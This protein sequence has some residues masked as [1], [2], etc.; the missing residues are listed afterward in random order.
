MWNIF[1]SLGVLFISLAISIPVFARISSQAVVLGLVL[2]LAGGIVLVGV[3]A[4]ISMDKE[5]ANQA[6]LLKANQT[7]SHS[8]FSVFQ[9]IRDK[10]DGLPSGGVGKIFL[11]GSNTVVVNMGDGKM[12]KGFKT[13]NTYPLAVAL[14]SDN[15]ILDGSIS[16]ESNHWCFKIKEGDK[17]AYYNQ[18]GLVVEN[19]V[20]TVDEDGFLKDSPTLGLAACLNGVVYGSDGKAE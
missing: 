7:F 8:S 18:H 1:L 4:N 3:G 14:P 20:T 19:V 5:K 11:Q 9:V 12:S 17:I 10:Q 16:S 13:N 15:Y 6:S 2:L